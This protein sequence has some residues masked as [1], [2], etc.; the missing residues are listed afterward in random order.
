MR[1]AAI[2]KAERATPPPSAELPKQDAACED[3]GAGCEG[4]EEEGIFQDDAVE[5]IE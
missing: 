5:E 1:N 2:E 3:E 4:E